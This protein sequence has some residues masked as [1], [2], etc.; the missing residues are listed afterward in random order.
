MRAN[1]ESVIKNRR[2][3]ESVS[4]GTF[5]SL[6]TMNLTYNM[7]FFFVQVALVT[8]TVISSHGFAR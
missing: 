7:R 2:T 3:N 5:G 4:R 6:F 8:N 1:H